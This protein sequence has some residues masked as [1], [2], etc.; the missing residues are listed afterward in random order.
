MN[1]LQTD[2]VLR[3]KGLAPPQLQA[4]VPNEKPYTT[5]FMQPYGS[6][7]TSLAGVKNFDPVIAHSRFSQFLKNGLD[8][9][10]DLV[11]TPEYSMPWAT[12]VDSIE[13][14][15]VP[16]PGALWVLGCESIA[17]GELEVIRTKLASVATLI[18]EP[19]PLT[20]GNFVDP[21]AYVFATNLLDETAS[22][23]LVVL[24]QFKNRAMGGANHFET[25]RLQTGTVIYRFGG[26]P[27]QEIT[28]VTLICSDVLDFVD[29]DAKAIYE[30]ALIIHIQLNPEPRHNDFRGYRDRLIQYRNHDTEIICVNWEANVQV[31]PPGSVPHWGNIAGSA[32]YV[33]PADLDVSDGQ[34]VANHR[35]GLYYTYL[36]PRRYHALFFH[37]D[38]ATFRVMATKAYLKGVRAGVRSGP[39]MVERKV[40][41]L[42]SEAWEVSNEPDD[43]FAVQSAESGGAQQA[44]TDIAAQN[45]FVAERILALSSGRISSQ[46]PWHAIKNVDSCIIDSTEV[47]KRITFCQDPEPSASEFR[48]RRLRRTANLWEILK[49]SKFPPA[50]KDIES[51]FSLAWS[52]AAPHQNVRS[53]DDRLA[54]VIYMGEESTRDELANVETQ[55]HKLLDRPGGNPEEKDKAMQRVVVFY[56]EG[57]SLKKLPS[58]YIG[59]GT[60]RSQ[61]PTGIDREERES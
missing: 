50:L 54:T 30:R 37:Y 11:I 2:E 60:S 15:V 44:L 48:A 5:F 58:A 33:G 21:L 24:V 19:E 41:N 22:V 23:Q 56:R 46:N 27:N 8:V 29:D 25:G 7:E 57:G 55:V 61:S 35:M 31:G 40:W 6:I 39:E 49:A 47:V 3:A 45:P 12:L 13:S 26:S 14:G 52:P 18:W 17:L 9:A 36:A 42:G 38:A 1:F 20:T 53:S 32:W 59:F 51:G 28:L 10:A 43:G 34:L 4:L 16:T